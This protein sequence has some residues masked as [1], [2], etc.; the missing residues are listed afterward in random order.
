MSPTTPETA[1]NAISPHSAVVTLPLRSPYLGDPI[2]EQSAKT[3]PFNF[4][5][6]LITY[7]ATDI[8]IL[9]TRYLPFPGP[10]TKQ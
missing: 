5:A 3:N 4:V 8:F 7:L 6:F 1:S 10:I 9:I 2:T